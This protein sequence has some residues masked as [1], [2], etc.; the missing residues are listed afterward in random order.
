MKKKCRSAVVFALALCMAAPTWAQAPSKG[1]SQPTAST[2]KKP[3]L[4][5]SGKPRKGKAS[6]YGK[7]FHGRKMADGTPMDPNSNIAASRTL[8][9]GTKAVVTNLENGRSEVVE[10]RD[11]GPYVDGR[12]VDLTPKTAE[13]LGMK[14]EG[15]ATVEVKPIELPPERGKSTLASRSV[16]QSS[17]Q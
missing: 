14:E 5:R 9:L 8:P 6:Y 15:L 4:D 1:D 11:R 7:K 16:E 2:S 12:I 3:Q 13:K 10:I 17:G